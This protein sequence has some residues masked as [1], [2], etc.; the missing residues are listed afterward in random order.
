MDAL[1]L[2]FCRNE[3]VEPRNLLLIGGMV[4]CGECLAQI[5]PRS[6]RYMMVVIERLLV[7]V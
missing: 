2:I 6:Y 3:G 7:G 1:L 5:M 4:L